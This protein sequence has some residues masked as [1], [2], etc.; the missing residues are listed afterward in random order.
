MRGALN[1]LSEAQFFQP[2]SKRML[3][4]ELKQVR[5]YLDEPPVWQAARAAV[6]AQIAADTRVLVAHSLGSVVAYEA[7]CE[8]PEWPVTTLVT[9][10]SPQTGSD[11]GRGLRGGQVALEVV[12]PHPVCDRPDRGTCTGTPVPDRGWRRCVIASSASFRLPTCTAALQAR[13]GGRGWP[14]LVT[15]SPS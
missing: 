13:P 1:A 2:A 3:V 15:S 4:S 5:R 7:L 12:H 8:N 14:I 10:G 11:G 6:A 9:V